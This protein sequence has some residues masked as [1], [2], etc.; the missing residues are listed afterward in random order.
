MKDTSKYIL[1]VVFSLCFSTVRVP[2]HGS[3]LIIMRYGTNGDG[4]SSISSFVIF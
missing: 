3:A 4:G 1:Q 2:L